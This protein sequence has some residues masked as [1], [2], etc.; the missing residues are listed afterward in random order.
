MKRTTV[1]TLI[2]VAALTAVMIFFLLFSMD[3]LVT[4]AIE[5]YGSQA[6]GADV[7]LKKTEISLKSGKGTLTGL[8]VANPKGFESES[9][10]ELGE[11]S[12][13]IDAPTITKGT[14]V[15]KEILIVAPNVTYEIGPEGSNLDVLQKNAAGKGGGSGGGDAPQGGGTSKGGKKLIIESL[16]I[17]GGKVNVSA[18][19]LQGQ[20]MTV[21]MP[22]VRMA[23]IGKNEGGVTPGEVVKKLIDA[24]NQAVGG[25]VK[26]L[27]LGKVAD[28]VEGV[29]KGAKDV[30]ES[31]DPEK[32]QEKA[33]ELGNA[34]KGL[35]GK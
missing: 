12:L 35:F 1:V 25:A 10:F 27:D 14:V 23:N 34:V 30:L 16:V 5:K 18:M 9:A 3:S 20:K 8:Q 4:M 24:F 19:G 26:N 22:T 28:E 32:I 31:G 29:V 13:T 21:D 2:M 15:I 33:E 17:R 6:L 11:I 7:T